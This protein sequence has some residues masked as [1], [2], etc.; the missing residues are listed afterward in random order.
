[1]VM[2]LSAG[3]RLDI[4]NRYALIIEQELMI[5]GIESYQILVNGATYGYQSI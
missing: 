1:M 2:G 3:K 5:S 4:L